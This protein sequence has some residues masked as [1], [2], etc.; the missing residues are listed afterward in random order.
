VNVGLALAAILIICTVM[1]RSIVAGIIFAVA[2]V[3]ANAIA[4]TYMNFNDIGL[5]ADTIP[6][7]SLGIGLGIS[8]A[9]YIVA[10]MR[11][12]ALTGLNLNDA[13]E[14]ALR[15]TG[16]RVVTTFIVIIGGIVPWVF[17]PMLFHYQMSVLLILLMVTNL[18]AGTVVVPALIV[19][20]RPRFMLKCT[21][22]GMTNR[23]E[24]SGFTHAASS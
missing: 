2:A 20:T 22:I 12:E 14:A 24:P 19:W 16:A 5:T 9:I 4:F 17:S 21:E 13:A 10:R 3:M 23:R 6:L 1:F 11:D 15:S 18:L 7:I 8:F